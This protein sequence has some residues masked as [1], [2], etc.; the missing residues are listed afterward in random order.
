MFTI[1]DIVTIIRRL[2]S[3]QRM[4]LR[5]VMKIS[6]L[7][8]WHMSFKMGL[9]SDHQWVYGGCGPTDSRLEKMIRDDTTSLELREI[10]NH[11]G[12]TKLSVF[13]RNEVAIVQENQSLDIALNHVSSHLVDISWA[14][15]AQIVASTYPMSKHHPGEVLAMRQCASEYNELLSHRVRR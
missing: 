9:S 5:R 8:D 10:D 1:P 3:T 15:L 6:Y 7:L 13:C 14:E 12:G 11:Y 4:S 2:S